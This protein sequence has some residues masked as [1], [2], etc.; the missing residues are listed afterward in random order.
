M[1]DDDIHI[2]TVAMHKF[3]G[4]FERDLSALIRKAD[5]ENRERLLTAF[6]HKVRQYGPGSI[7]FVEVQKGSVSV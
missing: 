1:S 6:S 4:H 2:M 3:G 5:G 7:A